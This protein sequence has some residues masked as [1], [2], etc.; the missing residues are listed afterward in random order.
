MKCVICKQGETRHGTTTITLD[1]NCMTFVVKSV[2]A[3]VCVNCGEGYVDEAITAQLLRL[4]EEAAKDGV[5][6]DI[7]EYVAA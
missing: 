6:V 4:A 2:P 7:R 1:R 5:Q 3:R